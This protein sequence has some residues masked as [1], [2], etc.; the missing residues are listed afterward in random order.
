MP[1][2][3][4]LLVLGFLVPLL[5]AIAG[6]TALADACGQALAIP[7]VEVKLQVKPAV[8]DTKQGIKALNATPRSPGPGAAAIGFP[9]T[10]GLT[11][12]A[13]SSGMDARLVGQP[14]STGDYCW[15]I[16][17]LT[18]KIEATIVVSIANEIPRNSCLWREVVAHEQR[19]VAIAQK[20]LPRMDDYMRPRVYDAATRSAAARNDREAGQLMQPPIVQVVKSALNEL[21]AELEA[22][23]LRIDTVEEYT[24]FSR[25]CGQAEFAAVLAKAG[26]QQ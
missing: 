18:I 9:Q 6:N 2:N 11:R 14:R 19:H 12:I 24:R 13:V 3:A 22:Q 10:M 4:N 1:S 25:A 20:F 21:M 7:N 17:R 16:S 23:Q 26:I 15:S 5:A 8:Y